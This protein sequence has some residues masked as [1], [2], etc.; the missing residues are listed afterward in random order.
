MEGGEDAEV[1]LVKW[2]HIDK[3][4]QLRLSLTN[5]FPSRSRQS[6][7]FFRRLEQE[8][9]YQDSSKSRVRVFGRWHQIPRKQAGYGDPGVAYSFSGTSVRAKAW[10]PALQELRE[11]VQRAAGIDYN[12]V[13][14]NRYADGRDHIGEH[15][16]DE[17]ELDIDAP[18]ASLTLGA[19]RD[20][21][22]KHESARKKSSSAKIDKVTLVLKDGSLLLMR[23]PTNQHWY[24]A[25]PPRKRCREV[26]INLT[27]RKINL[28]KSH[29]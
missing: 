29:G 7:D 27:F 1:D 4:P 9:E 28:G 26:R 2:T 5:L 25:L 21:Y 22:F 12:L 3:A 16:D 15:K 14:V 23:P 11:L 20:F 6:R 10:T 13:L 17:K 19:E 8:V 18:I 24:H